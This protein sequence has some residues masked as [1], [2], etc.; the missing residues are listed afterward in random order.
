MKIIGIF[1]ILGILFSYVPMIPIDGCR[2][3]G[4]VGNMKLDCGYSFHCPILSIVI[5]EP[6]HP[7]YVGRLALIPSLKTVEEVVHPIFHPPEFIVTSS[8]S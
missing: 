4:H 5:S 6:F 2:E 3:E 1:L 8:N 7:S